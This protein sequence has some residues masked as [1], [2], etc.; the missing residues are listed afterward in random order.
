MDEQI[1][2]PLWSNADAED[3]LCFIIFS[4]YVLMS[5]KYTLNAFMLANKKYL[6]NK[7]Q[8]D[9]NLYNLIFADTEFEN[10]FMKTDLNVRRFI[11]LFITLI[12]MILIG[13]LIVPSRDEMFQFINESGLIN[14]YLIILSFL[15]SPVEEEDLIRFEGQIEA[16]KL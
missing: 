9:Y 12:S 7:S 5:I 8:K 10:N 4:V 3:Y 16:M 14:V 1:S 11:T 13:L 2:D 15:I 6:E